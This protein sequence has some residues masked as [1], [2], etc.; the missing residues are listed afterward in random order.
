MAT[1]ARSPAMRVCTVVAL[2]LM[3]ACTHLSGGAPATTRDTTFGP[4]SGADDS[5]ANGTYSWKGV[6]FA[7]APVGELRW[8]PPVDPQPWASVRPA[9]GVM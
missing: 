5:A 9:T 7:Q 1:L 8:K 6:P 4:V 2:L 3:Q